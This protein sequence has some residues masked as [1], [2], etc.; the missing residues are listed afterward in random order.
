[1]RILI[2]QVDAFTDESFRG[3]PAA[4]C[5]YAGELDAQW[6]Q[7][8]ASEM[9]LS[10]TAFVSPR[11]DGGFSLRWFTP[12]C[13]VD[14]CGHA[15]LATAHTLWESGLVAGGEQIQ[16]HSRGGLLAA[17]KRGD[18]IRL[19]FPAVQVEKASPTAT[20]ARA[21]G[22]APLEFF[23]HA[24]GTLALLESADAVRDLEP[25]MPALAKSA[26]D[27][28]IVTAA[29]EDDETDFVSRV[30]CPRI[31]IP[32]DPVTGAAHCCLGPYWMEKL[33]KDRLSAVQESSRGGSVIVE[34]LGSRVALE[35]R[36]VTVFRGEIA[37]AAIPPQ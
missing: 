9:N 4:V 11:A 35:G 23:K 6:M 5:V 16:F 17:E 14:L 3:N 27:L 29:G 32:E 18:W 26:G 22:A 28:H 24:F 33:S 25:R 2:F 19:D 30:F 34:V 13:E 12:D 15:T 8:M 36:A 31:G 7:K 20:Y 1:M 10:E 37:P 21:L